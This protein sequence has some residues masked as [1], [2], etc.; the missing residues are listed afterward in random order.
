MCMVRM[1]LKKQSYKN[2]KID[3]PDDKI[4]AVAQALS[5]LLAYQVNEIQRSD[6]SAIVSF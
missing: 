6:Q 1:Y 4:Y 2:V 3:A 5:P